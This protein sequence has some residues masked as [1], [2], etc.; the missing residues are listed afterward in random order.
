[1]CVAM[2]DAYYLQSPGRKSTLLF[3]ES[4]ASAPLSIY[5]YDLIIKY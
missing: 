3:E 2:P 5:L 4:C 1:M